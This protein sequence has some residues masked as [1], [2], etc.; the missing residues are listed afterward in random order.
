[1]VWS[2]GGMVL[3]GEMVWSN[4]GMVLTGEMVWSNG[5]MVL[6]GEMVWSNGGMVLTGENRSSWINTCG[7]VT[8]STTVLTFKGKYQNQVLVVSRGRTAGR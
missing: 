1:M 8:L 2:N 7:K 6:T 4:G 5:G 3:T